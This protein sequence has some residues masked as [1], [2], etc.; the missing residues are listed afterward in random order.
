MWTVCV[1][2]Y[3]VVNQLC[4]WMAEDNTTWERVLKITAL[5]YVRLD[6]QYGVIMQKNRAFAFIRL[7][8]WGKNSFLLRKQCY[9]WKQLSY[10]HI[11][12][13][14]S[15]FCSITLLPITFSNVIMRR[16]RDVNVMYFLDC[17]GETIIWETRW[18]HIGFKTPI[19]HT[20]I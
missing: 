1:I 6:V 16:F 12:K 8:L 3:K 2:A 13:H 15:Q 17:N 18:P 19:V 10:C 11:T 7:C 4:R 20:N 14:Q 5:T 9:F